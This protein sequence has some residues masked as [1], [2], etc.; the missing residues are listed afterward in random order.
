LKGKIETKPFL[1][2]I[3]NCQVDDAVVWGQEVKGRTQR[4]GVKIEIRWKGNMVGVEV[5]NELKL[6]RLE[7]S[8]KV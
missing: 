8:S 3:V 7:C 2:R 4:V 1:M 6:G 5:A